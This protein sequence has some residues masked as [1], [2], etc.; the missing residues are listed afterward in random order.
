MFCTKCGKN[1]HEGDRF[2]SY[3]G[4]AVKKEKTHNLGD[5]EFKPPFKIEAE[6][7]TEEILTGKKEITHEERPSV[8]FDWNLDGFPDREPKKTQDIDFNWGGL[9]N[10]FKGTNS[11]EEDKS[12][13]EG[14]ISLSGEEN[15]ESVDFSPNPWDDLRESKPDEF[16]FQEGIN[17]ISQLERQSMTPL[18]EKSK[19]FTDEFVI[20]QDEVTKEAVEN[21]RNT[22][23]DFSDLVTHDIKE[24]PDIK[25]LM[26]PETSKEAEEIQELE[27]TLFGEEILK[28]NRE[29]KLEKTNIYKIEEVPK[30]TD[31]HT[32]NQKIDAFQS[33]LD[34]EKD[35]LMELEG[36]PQED[37]SQETHTSE[38]NKV[39][40]ETSV[41][42]IN[43]PPSHMT[44]DPK[45]CD[46]EDK[47]ELEVL[48][49]NMER[50]GLKDNIDE[51]KSQYNNEGKPAAEG[52]EVESP[53]QKENTEVAVGE[54]YKPITV[55]AYTKAGNEIKTEGEQ[56]NMQD[57][58]KNSLSNNKDDERENMK[59]KPSL[60]DIFMDEEE[61]QSS[62]IVRK[63]II[64]ILILAFIF[65]GVI[66]GFKL[67]QPD[68]KIATTSDKY[69]EKCVTYIVSLVTG[70]KTGATTSVDVD[71]VDVDPN[72][73]YLTE[74]VD[75]EKNKA[76][77]IGEIVFD[78]N[79]RYDLDK[80]YAFDEIN[81]SEGFKDSEWQEDDNGMKLTYGKAVIRRVIS[82][83]DQWKKKNKNKE[84]IGINKL[85]I[86]EIRQ[87]EDGYFNLVKVSYA[88]KDGKGE[89]KLISLFLEPIQDKMM[90]SA[91][92][93]EE[94]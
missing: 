85:S 87:T 13:E 34:K 16:Q 3:C 11:Y 32:F 84:L 4:T 78:E 31:F 92:K 17:I 83:F 19:D 63:T 77:T 47:E 70:K 82:H 38:D 35:K 91:I 66:L 15:H 73:P 69:I 24:T 25:P 37:V 64:G 28:T 29:S 18:W 12:N 26:M 90:L 10:D 36:E 80:K 72:V 45:T 81:T 23:S 22:I 93:E 55:D 9:V 5:A 51:E 44:E 68:G 79:I 50:E 2:C 65:E 20:K 30:K 40:Q 49:K 88:T 21:F 62:H 61:P 74:L 46:K 86:G 41:P 39:S 7:R 42:V 71:D 67:L 48:E 43:F 33:L 8:V 14:E 76:T 6:R 56:Q 53:V 75:I 52:K 94:I 27:K 89:E 59:E 1:L 54:P 58:N 57:M 60:D